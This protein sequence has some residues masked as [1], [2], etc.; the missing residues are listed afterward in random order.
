MD[1]TFEM[2]QGTPTLVFERRIAHPPERVWAAI[3]E[4]DQLEHWFPSEV[5]FEGPVESGTPI[6]FTFRQQVLEDQP[7]TMTGE[8]KTIE[9]PRRLVF[10]WGEDELEFEL[11][12]TEDRKG[13]LLRFAVALDDREKAARDGAGWHVCLDRLELGLTQTPTDAPGSEPTNEWREHY[14]EYRRRGFPATAA[15]P[16]EG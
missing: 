5:R 9:P 1:A 15:L 3:T 6:T 16:G 14:E 13:C 10:S 8:I 2:V 12:P 7:M 11:E 4:P